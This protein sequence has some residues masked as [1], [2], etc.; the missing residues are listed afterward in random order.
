MLPMHIINRLALG[1]DLAAA[2]ES[3]RPGFKAWVYIWPVVA[4][5]NYWKW[6]GN[7]G[8][9]PR[10]VGA[11]KDRICGYGVRYVEMDEKYHDPGMDADYAAADPTTLD[12]V[13]FVRDLDELALAISRYTTDFGQLRPPPNVL[14]PRLPLRI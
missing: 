11:E 4:L 9:E 1:R 2:L 12:E 13:C 5:P 6:S 8:S 14:Y 7:P 10:L 3:R